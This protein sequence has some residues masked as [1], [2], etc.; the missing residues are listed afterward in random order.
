MGGR[1]KKKSDAEGESLACHFFFWPATS[2][3]LKELLLLVIVAPFEAI[4][5]L[6]C[7][8]CLHFAS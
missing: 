4:L 5:E 8:F 2:R 1:K 7:P 6:I 3:R